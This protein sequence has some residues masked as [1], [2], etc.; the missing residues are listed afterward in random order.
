MESA[1]EGFEGFGGLEE[2]RSLRARAAW[3]ELV[4]WL[5]LHY[6]NI[7]WR[8]VRRTRIQYVRL[9]FFFRW[10]RHMLRRRRRHR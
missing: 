3:G 1:P 2:E 5:S 9:E 4:E 8:L 6:R 7:A 10:A